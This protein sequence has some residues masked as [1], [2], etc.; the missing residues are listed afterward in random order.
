MIKIVPSILAETRD[1]ML[2]DFEKVRGLVDE[3]QIDIIDGQFKEEV[4]V[5]PEK[6]EE[7]DRET[8]FQAHLMVNKPEDWVLKCSQCGFKTV[9]GQ[10]EKMNSIEDFVRKSYEHNMEVGLGF[11]IGTD[12]NILGKW[13]PSIDCVLLMAVQAGGQGRQFDDDVLKKIEAVRRIDEDVKIMID[14]GLN[15]LEIR[16]C[17][18]VGKRNIECAVGSDLLRATNIKNELAKLREMNV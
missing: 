2:R 1:Q 3:V 8:R 12:V 6:V 18:E 15:P 5:W 9:Y 4:T 16:R 17:W 7:L 14:G 10:V 11:D 13:M